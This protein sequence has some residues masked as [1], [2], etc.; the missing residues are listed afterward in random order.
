[1]ID[2]WISYLTFQG[3]GPHKQEDDSPASS[4]EFFPK[5]VENTDDKQKSKE[6]LLNIHTRWNP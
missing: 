5:G 2:I 3:I 1:M 4:D 6:F